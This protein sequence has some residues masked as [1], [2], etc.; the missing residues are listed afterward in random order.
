MPAERFTNCSLEGEKSV[1]K[2]VSKSFMKVV[3]PK[4]VS[5]PDLV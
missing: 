4:L 2:F 3:S 5:V 1:S